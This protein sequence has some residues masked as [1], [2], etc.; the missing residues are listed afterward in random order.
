MEL[1]N[2]IVSTFPVIE[3]LFTDENFNEF[4]SMKF[5]DLCEYHFTL[6]VWIRNN[7][8]KRGSRLEK[9]FIKGGVD[10]ADDMS[11]LIIELFYIY[12]KSKKQ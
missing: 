4:L 6:G 12:Q 9:M 8:V 3:N 7:L 1:V 11:R 2:A 5:E 10:G